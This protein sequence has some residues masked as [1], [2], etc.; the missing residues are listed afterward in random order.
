[1]ILR[2]SPV[3]ATLDGGVCQFQPLLTITQKIGNRYFEG[4]TRANISY[5]Y[6]CL[7]Q[8]KKAIRYAKL[9]LKIADEISAKQLKAASIIMFACAYWHKKKYFRSLL[10]AVKA[11]LILPPWKSENGKVIFQTTIQKISHFWRQ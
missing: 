8:D 7:K 4:F 5:C 1:M 6:G 2:E 9:A 11:I 3:T 10:L